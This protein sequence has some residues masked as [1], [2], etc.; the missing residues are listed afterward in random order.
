LPTVHIVIA[1]AGEVGFFLA[2]AFYQ[3]GN[4]VAI[5]ESAGPAAD[6]A[7]TLDAK[8]VRGSAASLANL[9]EAGIEKAGLFLGVTSSDE[10][11][12]I[13]CAL[14]KQADCRTIA[15]ING[16]DFMNEPVSTTRYKSLG[17]DVAVCPDLVA[18]H[19]IAGTLTSP[20]MLDTTAFAGGRIQVFEV[21]PGPEAPILGKPVQ[22]VQWPDYVNLCAILREPD[23]VIPHG[24]DVIRRGDSV[25]LTLL[26]G[27]DMPALGA[28]LDLPD[29]IVRAAPIEK[30]IVAGAT[31][32]G[33]HISHLLEGKADITLVE[34]D[35]R[36]CR[37]AGEELTSTLVVHGAYT[38]RDLLEDEGI[39]ETDAFVGATERDGANILSCLLAKRLGARRVLSLLDEADLR[40]YVGEIGIEHTTSPRYAAVAAILQNAHA[41]PAFDTLHVLS[42][43]EARVLEVR[44]SPDAKIGGLP[45]K[46]TKVPADTI[47]AAVV[48]GDDALIP[49]GDFVIQ[50]GDRLILFARTDAISKLKKVL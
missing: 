43:G 21:K 4:D 35:E 8:V 25:V 6:R 27:A 36:L 14:A 41:D 23:V 10:T 26:Q 45:L 29:R 28:L 37:M 44:V 24:L 34:P 20:T 1:G 30:V 22:S 15:R 17:I 49:H 39:A 38:D 13:A 9:N 5:I 32:I 12:M 18:A 16:R 47:V 33:I 50:S 3:S 2:R 19:R 42:E 46:R 48:R 11:N 7:E 40:P 31:R